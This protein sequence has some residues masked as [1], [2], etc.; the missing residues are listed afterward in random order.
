MLGTRVVRTENGGN[1]KSRPNVLP[2]PAIGHTQRRFLRLTIERA[3]ASE[4]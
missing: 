2:Y 4:I 3:E 1:S